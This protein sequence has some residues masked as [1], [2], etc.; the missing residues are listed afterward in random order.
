[1]NKI[2]LT[3]LFCLFLAAC[4]RTSTPTPSTGGGTGTGSGS[5]TGGGT[6]GGTGG[7]TAPTFTG[8]FIPNWHDDDTLYG[9]NVVGGVSMGYD[10]IFTDNVNDTSFVRIKGNR[11]YI[12]TKDMSSVGFTFDPDDMQHQWLVISPTLNA[13]DA[14]LDYDASIA[15]PYKYKTSTGEVRYQYQVI[16]IWPGTTSLFSY[17][18]M[19][20]FTSFTEYH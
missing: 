10:T 11:Y 1:M 9:D 16:S 3:L 13:A 8:H 20:I 12:W 14:V 7:G 4:G 18:Y 6:S 19:N 15:R 17:T 2:S 5:G